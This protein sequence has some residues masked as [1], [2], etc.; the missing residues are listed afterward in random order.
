M[1]IRSIGLFAGMTLVA[2]APLPAN[3]SAFSFDDEFSSFQTYSPATP[4]G[5]DVVGGPQWANDTRPSWTAD[6][7][8]G[9]V[10]A[11]GTFPFNNELQWYVNP[12]YV[13]PAGQPALPNPFS[14][15][16]GALN[17]T[18]APANPAIA[19]YFAAFNWECP[20]LC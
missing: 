19:N 4:L 17:I 3:A 1:K 10:I 8:P 2:G 13:P 11:S 6:G 9:R 16:N 7:I 12:N 20:A 15:S 5:W 14:I 18:A